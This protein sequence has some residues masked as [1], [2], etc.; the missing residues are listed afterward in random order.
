MGILIGDKESYYEENFKDMETNKQK[1]IRGAYGKY[2]EELKHF[3]NDKGWFDK[4]SF[5]N[6]TFSFGVYE[7]IDLLFVHKED[8]MIP[9]SIENI[10][11]NNGWIS[12][13]SESDLPTEDCDCHIEFEDGAISIDRYF[14]FGKNFTSNHW[15]FIVA[16]RLIEKPNKRIY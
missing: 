16:Y 11:N 8:F 7:N 14:V 10:E 12:I 9:K 6:N 15:R 13:L 3:I 2:W 1:A 4:N 5:W